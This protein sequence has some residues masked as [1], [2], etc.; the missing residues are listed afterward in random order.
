MIHLADA[1]RQAIHSEGPN[2]WEGRCIVTT[3][4]PEFMDCFDLQEEKAYLQVYVAERNDQGKTLFTSMDAVE[5]APWLER[6]RLGEAV[7]RR[8]I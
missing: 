1:M 2:G 3:H 8:F 6:Y 4:S 7:R 5:F